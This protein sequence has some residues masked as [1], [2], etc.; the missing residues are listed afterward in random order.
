LLRQSAVPVVLAVTLAL[1]NK[2]ERV[3]TRHLAAVDMAAEELVRMLA[4][5]AR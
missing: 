2:V 3:E 4:V 5:A 1:I